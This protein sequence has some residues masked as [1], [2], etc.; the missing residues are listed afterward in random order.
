MLPLLLALTAA[1]AADDDVLAV[2][3]FEVHADD[4]SWQEMGS[5]A[6]DMMVTDLARGEG[7]RLVERSRIEEILDELALQQTDLVDPAS[8]QRLGHGLG[9]T[10]LVLGSVTVKDGRVRLDARLVDVA[11][12]ERVLGEQAEG[13]AD[14]F[15]QLERTLAQRLLTHLEAELDSDDVAYFAGGDPVARIKRPQPPQG[16][17]RTTLSL[18]RR[19]AK[20]HV[21]VDGVYVGQ[22]SRGEPVEADVAVGVHE[23]AIAADPDGVALRALGV[24]AVPSAGV[25]LKTL[26]KARKV[27]DPVAEPPWTTVRKDRLVVIEGDESFSPNVTVGEVREAWAVRALNLTAGEHTVVFTYDGTYDVGWACSGQIHVAP[28][29]SVQDARILINSG[30]CHGFDVPGTTPTV[31]PDTARDR[32]KAAKEAAEAAQQAAEAAARAAEGN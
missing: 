30:G 4:A 6:A 27:L 15:F 18:G 2:L 16:G 21:F 5:G 8:A 19:L 3:P 25:T 31:G 24:V 22:H 1:S 23:V 26:H 29:G 32:A 10:A 9:A 17:P 14:A 11:T 13:D 12:G 28:G 20:S 7:V